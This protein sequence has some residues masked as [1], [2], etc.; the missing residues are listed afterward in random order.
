[1]KQINIKNCGN[2]PFARK[3]DNGK[4]KFL[5]WNNNKLYDFKDLGKIHK[6]CKLRD[7]VNNVIWVSLDVHEQIKVIECYLDYNHR[8]Q[9]T[10]KDIGTKWERI[11]E[12]HPKEI[13]NIKKIIEEYDKI[14]SK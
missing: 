13:Q 14:C 12:L 8:Q 11:Y 1:M 10:E 5:C 6:D 7:K 4:E 2:C 3:G 9:L